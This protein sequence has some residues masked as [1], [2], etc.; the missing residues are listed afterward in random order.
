MTEVNYEEMSDM[1]LATVVKENLRAFHETVNLLN[2]RNNLTV[3]FD[4]SNLGNNRGIYTKLTVTTKIVNET[5][6]NYPR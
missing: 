5:S 1:E 2:T 3:I 4:G 6:D